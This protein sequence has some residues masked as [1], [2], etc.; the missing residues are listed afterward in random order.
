MNKKDAA[1][2]FLLIF[3]FLL[4]FILST[5]LKKEGTRAEIYSDGALLGS[6]PL[7]EDKSIDISGKNKVAVKD[8]G[9]YMESAL[10]PDKI[11]VKTGKIKNKGE[12]IVCLP[13]KLVI[14]IK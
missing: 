5:A 6:Y 3:V 7:S 4:A 1:L 14:K 11:C 9:V 8:G 13:N 2:I 10:C 12:E